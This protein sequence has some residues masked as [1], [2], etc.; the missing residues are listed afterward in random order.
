[1]DKSLK[2]Q[3][4]PDDQERINRLCG[5]TNSTLRQIEEALKIKISNRGTLFKVKGDDQRTLAAE[6]VLKGLYERLEKNIDVP[7]QEIHL[8]LREVMNNKSSTRDGNGLSEEESTL[9]TPN[10]LVS[11]KATATTLLSSGDCFGSVF[12]LDFSLLK[13]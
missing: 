8:Y 5:P 11:P 6:I 1:M 13:K 7:P 2:F 10:S 3:L 12:F 4:V 9:R